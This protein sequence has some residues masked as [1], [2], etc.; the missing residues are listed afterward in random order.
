MT[1]KTL[2]TA[3]THTTSGPQGAA[4]SS[5]GQLDVQLPE[6]HPAA[7]RM[8]AAAWSACFLG[9]LELA[10]SRKKITLPGAPAIDATIDLLTENN[11]FFLRA[12]LDVSVPGVD[13]EVARELVDAA[14]GIC[15]YS[16]AT[17]GNI[18]VELNV[19]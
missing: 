11:G 9:A 12:R 8:F 16:K 19:V 14:H 6:P 5:D 15:P 7:E 1:A 17:R 18:E 10:A 2:F 13:R 4:R 3:K